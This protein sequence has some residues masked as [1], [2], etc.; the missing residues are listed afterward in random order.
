MLCEETEWTQV[1]Y[2]NGGKVLALEAEELR[3]DGCSLRT[4]RMLRKESMQP[5]DS[6]AHRRKTEKY[7]LHL[8]RTLERLHSG[9]RRNR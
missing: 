8:N 1:Q 5:M 9:F 6:V 3:K 7:I 2:G 4:Y